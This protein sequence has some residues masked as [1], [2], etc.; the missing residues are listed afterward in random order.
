MQL[1]ILL[2]TLFVAWIATPTEAAMPTKA[3]KALAPKLSKAKNL[4]IK[5]GDG[6]ADFFWRNKAA[7]GTAA[8]ITSVVA[9]PEPYAEA[10]GNAVSAT[11]G[12]VVVAVASPRQ[13]KMAEAP[14]DDGGWWFFGFVVV[15]V[16]SILIARQFFKIAIRNEPTQHSLVRHRKRKCRRK[17][18][19]HF[20][21]ILAISLAAT[22]VLGP[23]GLALAGPADCG[24]LIPPASFWQK[25]LNLLLILLL[26]VPC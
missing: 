10:A 4:L 3:V 11:A 24:V 13:A 16:I 26:L 15:I 1:K 18:V 19:R 22:I 25:L 21:M 2:C 20:S 14:K 17:S 6:A 23:S 12:H 9:T 5:T 8:V 7:I